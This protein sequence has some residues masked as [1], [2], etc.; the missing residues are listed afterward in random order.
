MAV[1]RLR[2]PFNNPAS[3]A[4]HTSHFVSALRFSFFHK[5]SLLLNS[6]SNHI[7][8]DSLSVS[9][10]PNVAAFRND[11]TDSPISHTQFSYSHRHFVYTASN[12]PFQLDSFNAPL[13]THTAAH[14]YVAGIVASKIVICVV[15]VKEPM[16]VDKDKQI[17]TDVAETRA[18]ERI[19]ISAV[20]VA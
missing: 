2:S 15:V 16:T 12:N 9:S 3:I 4:I 1:T 18:V 14:K 20:A 7:F 17:E 11:C 8:H 19:G 10:Y 6:R 13:E 5:T